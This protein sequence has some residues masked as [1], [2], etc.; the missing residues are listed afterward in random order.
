LNE[1]ASPFHEDNLA[2]GAVSVAVLAWNPTGP[3]FLEGLAVLKCHTNKQ[4]YRIM[5]SGVAVPA[6]SQMPPVWTPSPLHASRT[7]EPLSAPVSVDVAAFEKLHSRSEDGSADSPQQV[8][9]ERVDACK[10]RSLSRLSH[11]FE[12]TAR[13]RGRSHSS[14]RSVASSSGGQGRQRASSVKSDRAGV[15]RQRSVSRHA[16]ILGAGSNSAHRIAGGYSSRATGHKTSSTF[17]TPARSCGMR[18]SCH[19]DCGKLSGTPQKRRT[20]LKG[21]SVPRQSAQGS[22]KSTEGRSPAPRVPGWMRD[23][24]YAAP[25]ARGPPASCRASIALSDAG[26]SQKSPVMGPDAADRVSATSRACG[27]VKSSW[28]SSLRTSSCQ[29]ALDVPRTPE[30]LEPL[31]IYHTECAICACEFTSA[32]RASVICTSALS[33][34]SWNP[35]LVAGSIT[36]VL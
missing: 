11:S 14:S 4:T 32:A 34:I 9:L 31:S 8:R 5:C 21:Q 18:H 7:P 30:M 2:P 26:R 19:S 20:L 13:E 16:F 35:S 25:S 1:A 29:Q 22:V 17:G 23:A 28:S 33:A 10:R 6:F 3:G 27:R 24:G 12:D 36:S 15:C